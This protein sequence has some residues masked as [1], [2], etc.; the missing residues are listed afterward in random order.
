MKTTFRATG[1]SAKRILA[2]ILSAALCAVAGNVQAADLDP[3]YIEDVATTPVEFGSGW[4]L[5]GDIGAGFNTKG[6]LSYF[7]TARNDFSNQEFDHTY[8]AGIGAGFI[9]NEYFRADVTWDYSGD[10]GWSGSTLATTCTGATADCYNDDSAS[11]SRNTVMANVY[12]NLG[13]WYSISPYVGAGVGI[14]NMRWND[15]SSTANCSVDPGET[16]PYGTH[17]GGPGTET[18]TG[19]TTSYEGSY[20]NAFTWSLMGGLDFRISDKWKADIGYKFTRIGGGTVVAANANGPGDPF[21]DTIAD[22]INIH[23]VRFGLRYEIW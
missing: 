20:Y 17:S 7:S 22:D 1:K 18:F 8:S 21:G 19:P 5:R 2:P 10:N 16:C 15:Y 4:Y 6:N 9:F 3:V 12:A 23:E 13:E 14:T 11:F